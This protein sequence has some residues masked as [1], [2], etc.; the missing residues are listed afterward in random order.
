MP[1][2]CLIGDADLDTPCSA[3]RGDIA[4]EASSGKR[5][6]VCAGQGLWDLA[7]RREAV[8]ICAVGCSGRVLCASFFFV[9]GKEQQALSPQFRYGVLNR[10]RDLTGRPVLFHL[11]S[12]KAP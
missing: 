1:T 11:S 5:S 9:E 10:T 3:V 12:A 6:V 7:N 2:T 8:K 4:V